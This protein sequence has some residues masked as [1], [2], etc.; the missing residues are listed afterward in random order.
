[1]QLFNPKINKSK[2]TM[3]KRL[4]LILTLFLAILGNAVAQD[5]TITGT[6]TSAE[7]GSP[8]PGVNILVSGTTNVG[9]ITD[10]NGR[11]SLKVPEGFKALE[12]SYIGTKSQ[13]IELTSSN[14]IDVSLEM[15]AEMLSEVVVTALGIKRDI[16]AI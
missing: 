5:R 16:K 8:L 9:T 12:F 7:D 14:V 13:A 3:R 10:A 1:M 2:I 15:E 4:L 6:V 11:F